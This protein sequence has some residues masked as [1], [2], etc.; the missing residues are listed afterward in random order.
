MID[1]E[2]GAVKAAPQDEGPACTVPEA[3]EK[4][5]DHQVHVAMDRTV[6]ISSEWNVKVVAQECSKRHVQ[7]A[8]EFDYVRRFVWRIEV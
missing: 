1:D 3:A 2:I 5:C 4:H 8:P 7:T 6:T